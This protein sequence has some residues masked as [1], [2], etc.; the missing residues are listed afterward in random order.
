M[1]RT[2]A[3]FLTTNP[4]TK[5]QR[6]TCVLASLVIS[7]TL[8][9]AVAFGFTAQVETASTPIAAAVVVPTQAATH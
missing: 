5:R 1:T 6:A 4:L 8:V 3:E 7:A 9:G 2:T